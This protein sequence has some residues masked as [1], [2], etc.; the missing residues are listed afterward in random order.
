[1]D[2]KELLELIKTGEG[3][4]LEFKKQFTSSINRE[5]CAFANSKG[6]R[7]I[8][9]VDD[10]G[11]VV[12]YNL[13]NSEKSKIYDIARNMDPSFSVE[14]TSV[15]NLVVI[16]VSEGKDKPYAVHGHFYIRIG[17]NSQQL[18]REEILLFFQQQGQVKFDEKINPKF[19]YKTDFN[20]D[21]FEEFLD[22]ASIKLTISKERFLKNLGFLENNKLNNA[23][24]LFFCKNISRFFLNANITCVLFQGDSK[25]TVLDK[26]VFENDL[27]SNYEKTI[28]YLKNKLNTEY[29]IKTEREEYLELPED[30]LRE[31]LL[32]AIAHRD[33][34]SPS[35]I[36][37]NIFKNSVEIINP[38]SY[39]QNITIEDLL[40]G[41]HPKNVFL[42]SMMQRAD[43]VEKIGS[44]IKR[45]NDAMKDY[46]LS[47]PVIEYK[48][49][50]FR[51]IFNRPDLQKNSYQQRMNPRRR[52][53]SGEKVGRKRGENLGKTEVEI[54]E[55]IS[56]DKFVT[57]EELAEK[58]DLGTT[59]I[60]NNISKLKKKG[61]L[62][63]IGP[64]KGGHW[65]I[66][67]GE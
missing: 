3:Y 52:V 43:L 13:T 32:N 19:D 14:V 12:G 21:A 15:D 29:V 63:R 56:K 41:S 36:Q 51:I 8:L 33:Y 35:H 64:A 59:A 20:N 11:N 16:S 18:N 22:R 48:N 57:I 4:T 6:G 31:A 25:H 46:R 50:W 37:V 38:A 39:P 28:S 66:I 65:E 26:K 9:G 5:I 67:K 44:G 53:E 27:I 45:I 30:A 10:K 42:F 17:S 34:F 2:K 49:I 47:L 54:L 60:E 62:K 58:I 40:S 61:L 24:V 23:G 7:I 55:L 1:V